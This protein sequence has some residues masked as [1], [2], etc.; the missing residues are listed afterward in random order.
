MTENKR[1]H[2][3]QSIKVNVELGFDKISVEIGDSGLQRR[4]PVHHVLAPVDEAV[5]VETDES[6][7]HGQRETVVERKALA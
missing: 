5:A 1:K 4:R 6:L 2:P 3:R 7:A